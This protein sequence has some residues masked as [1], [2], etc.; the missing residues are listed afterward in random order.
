MILII[1]GFQSLY[2]F[3]ILEFKN[4]EIWI[5]KILKYSKIFEK[6]RFWKFLLLWYFIFRIQE[7]TVIFIFSEY[8]KVIE[9]ILCPVESKLWISTFLKL[10]KPKIVKF[11]NQKYKN[12]INSKI[13]YSKISICRD[14]KI[15]NFLKFL[16]YWKI[17][18]YKIRI[19]FFLIFPVLN[20]R[21]S[22]YRNSGISV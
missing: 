17:F 12:F 21:I 1:V 13:Q 11:P 20:L 16:S 3:L 4:S 22:E 10:N 14:S 6:C 15:R 7:F 9:S 18:V 2:F 19:I 8:L 5:R